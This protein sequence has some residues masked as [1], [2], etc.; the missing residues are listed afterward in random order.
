MLNH[1][2]RSFELFGRL[3]PMEEV[4]AELRAV[5]AP[6]AREAGRRLFESPAALASVDGGKLAL[7]A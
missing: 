3:M 7:A 5:D 1:H 4:L 6:S 2:A